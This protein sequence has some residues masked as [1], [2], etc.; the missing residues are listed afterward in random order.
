MKM[1]KYAVVLLSLFLCACQ[2]V[3]TDSSAASPVTSSA[4][5]SASGVPMASDA[6]ES[7]YQDHTGTIYETEKYIYTYEKKYASVQDE[8]N[9][10][11]FTTTIT[12]RDK[13]NGNEKVVWQEQNFT[14]Y[15]L[16]QY[17]EDIYFGLG[18]YREFTP[19]EGGFMHITDNTNKMI[20]EDAANI[21]TVTDE[22]IFCGNNDWVLKIYSLKEKRFIGVWNDVIVSNY[23][24]DYEFEYENGILI[25]ASEDGWNHF[26]YKTGVNTITKSR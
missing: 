13:T 10:P 24:N 21:C 18:D 8:A 5:N 19:F 12:R 25:W 9:P 6:V 15:F 4:K 17:G 14:A 3:N 20:T 1:K 11:Q 16:T 26:D 22:L 7:K 23:D 2:N